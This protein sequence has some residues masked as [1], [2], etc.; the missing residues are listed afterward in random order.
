MWRVTHKAVGDSWWIVGG[1]FFPLI[2]GHL[3]HWAQPKGPLLRGA[4]V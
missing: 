2:R 3:R 4:S 1:W